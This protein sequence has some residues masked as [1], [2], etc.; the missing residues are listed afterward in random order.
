V[1]NILGKNILGETK[2][3]LN[4]AQTWGTPQHY[5]RG[6]KRGE[7]LCGKKEW[8][9]RGFLGT[10]VHSKDREQTAQKKSIK[11][12]GRGGLGRGGKKGLGLMHLLYCQRKPNA[13]LKNNW[14]VNNSC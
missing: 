2:Q 12:F 5:L 14:E 1:G 6:G 4:W 8:I 13:R 9:L 3:L 10:F 7:N 11:F